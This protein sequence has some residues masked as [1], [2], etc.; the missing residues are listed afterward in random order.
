MLMILTATNFWQWIR[1]H[2]ELK[3]KFKKSGKFLADMVI[4]MRKAACKSKM[5][6]LK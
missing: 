2:S 1:Y 6:C 3:N 4:G 5:P